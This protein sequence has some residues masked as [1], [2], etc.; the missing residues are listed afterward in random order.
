MILSSPDKL[1]RGD[2][3]EDGM[4]YWGIT[5]SKGR[6]YSV[7]LEPSAFQKYKEK[8]QSTRRKYQIT[9]KN[10]DSTFKLIKDMRSSLCRIIRGQGYTKKSS[11]NEIYG[12]SWDDLKKHIELQ[13]KDGMSWSNR[14]EWHIDHIYPLAS[15]K[16]EQELLKLNHYKNLRPLWAKENIAKGSRHP[17]ELSQ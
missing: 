2:L 14:G 7:W 5:K 16:S 8:A 17:F 10:I 11:C 1:K 4:V 9:R 15:A 12:C 13:F 6:Y 3:R